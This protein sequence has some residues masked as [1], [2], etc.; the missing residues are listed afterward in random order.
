MHIIN[1]VIWALPA[2]FA[3][4]NPA[5]EERQL[6]YQQGAVYHHNLHRAN[7]SAPNLVWDTTIAATAM[8]IAKTC[9]FAHQMDIDA[10]GYGQNLA[11]GIPATNITYV[12]T[13]M[14]YNSE[15]NAYLPSYYGSEPSSSEF[16]K[17][18]HFSQVVWKGTTRLG[19]ATKDCSVDGLKG[20][21]RG[22]PPV[23]TVC[24]YKGPGNYL[25]QFK[26]NVLRPLNRPTV[27]WSAVP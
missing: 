16:G 5:L 18:G 12:V 1:I 15:V 4:P 13:D 23:L 19:C 10:G 9:N 26:D 11:A 17:Y 14:W 22:V 27:N 2:A 6:S 24:N 25:G 20:V 21:G 3:L 7:H 8:K